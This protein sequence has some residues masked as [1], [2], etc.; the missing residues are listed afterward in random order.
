MNKRSFPIALM[1]AFMAIT[2]IAFAQMPGMCDG[3]MGGGMMRH[4][5]VRHR[6]F[7]MNGIHARLMPS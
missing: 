7:M 2:G 5:M 3:M 1:V 6:Y 4:S